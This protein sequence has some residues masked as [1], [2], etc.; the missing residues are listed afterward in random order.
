MK[1]SIIKVIN[2]AAK[3]SCHSVQFAEYWGQIRSTIKEWAFSP[4]YLRD[5]LSN[6]GVELTEKQA[7]WL[8]KEGGL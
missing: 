3:Q 4:K 6:Q 2:D 8:S 7:Q 5:F 1:D